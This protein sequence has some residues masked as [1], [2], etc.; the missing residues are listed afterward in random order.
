MPDIIMKTSEE[1]LAEEKQ[2]LFNADIE[3]SKAR[4]RHVI[5]RVDNEIAYAQGQIIKH[6]QAKEKAQKL[7]AELETRYPTIV[8]K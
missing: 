2:V 6:E 5:A 1:L 7:L 4:Q 8:E 3:E